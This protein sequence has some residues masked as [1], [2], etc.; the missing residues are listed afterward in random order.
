MLK[1]AKP[2]SIGANEMITT[3]AKGVTFC[4]VDQR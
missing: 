3:D 4:A 2:T 1:I